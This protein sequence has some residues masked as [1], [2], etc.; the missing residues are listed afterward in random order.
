[1]RHA[2]RAAGNP[3]RVMSAAI[4]AEA[5][6]L[7]S[8][9][10][11]IDVDPDALMTVAAL[12][13]MPLVHALRRRFAG[14][15]DP[16]WQHGWC[17]VCGGWPTMAEQRGIE[18]ARRLRCA[19][20]GGD[21]TQPGIRCPYC[22]V[23]GHGARGALVVEDDGGARQVETCTACRGYLKSVSTLRAWAADEIALADL[24]TLDLDLVALERD[25]TRPPARSLS[26]PLVL[27]ALSSP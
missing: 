6:T 16:W 26:P 14:G 4:N 9:A 23:A 25:F 15:V 27:T 1:M 21:W 13:V 19:R 7:E 22:D 10:A 8:I 5:E 3:L 17:P 2:A 12:A 11:A 18:R 24:A 20:C